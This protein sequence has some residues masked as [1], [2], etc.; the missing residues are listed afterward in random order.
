MRKVVIM[1]QDT[2]NKSAAEQ[3]AA[4][5][6]AIKKGASAQSSAKTTT[7]FTANP[8]TA[9]KPKSAVT[10]GVTGAGTLNKPRV[11]AFTPQKPALGGLPAANKPTLGGTAAK[12]A[13]GTVTPAAKPAL[14][15]TINKPKPVIGNMQ[16]TP[17]P[18]FG[19]AASTAKPALGA[20]AG[21]ANPASPPAS[22]SRQKS[23]VGVVS[24]IKAVDFDGSYEYNK[25]DFGK[26]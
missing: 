5:L 7:P 21:T 13:L 4:R 18:A 3:L 17:K 15:T 20:A 6:E 10:T 1:G 11:N 24:V 12:P 8:S 16:N 23:S 22:Q 26:Y 19:T 2:N 14:G 9:L 25:K